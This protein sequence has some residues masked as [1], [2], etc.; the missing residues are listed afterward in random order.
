MD[1]RLYLYLI[2]FFVSVLVTLETSLGDK[3]KTIH[4]KGVKEKIVKEVIP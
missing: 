2:Y 3:L 4:V 1:K